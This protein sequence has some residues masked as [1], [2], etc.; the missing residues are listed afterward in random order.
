MKTTRKNHGP[1]ISITKAIKVTL[2]H[3]AATL[4]CDIQKG[5][6]PTGRTY[7]TSPRWWIKYDAS[8]CAMGP[9]NKRMVREYFAA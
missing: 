4:T 7:R 6:T 1:F 8:S 2:K 3:G 5:T 9:W